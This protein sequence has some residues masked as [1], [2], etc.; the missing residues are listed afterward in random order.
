MKLLLLEDD[1]LFGESVEEFL[2]EAGFSVV[3]VKS[4]SEALEAT[5]LQSFDVMVLDVNV[6]SP[7]G[8]EV[9]TQLRQGGNKTPALFLTSRNSDADTLRGFDVG[10]DDFLK[11]P[12]SL[13][14]LLVRIKTRIRGSFGQLHETVDLGNDLVFDIYEECITKGGKRIVVNP[15]E[16]ALLKILIKNK[17]HVVSTMMIEQEL[18]G[19]AN[20]ASYGAIRV[21]IANLKKIIGEEKIE[22]IRGVGYRLEEN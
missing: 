10:C 8:F 9:L 20:E 19:N 14:E 7:N 1:D 21:Y 13:Q 2:D 17:G 3:W 12:C 4:G 11:K 6:P 22:N 16:L 18:Y 5:F 15:K